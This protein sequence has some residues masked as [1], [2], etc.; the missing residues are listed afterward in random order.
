MNKT[1]TI[2]FWISVLALALGIYI[3]Q[4][5][6]KDARATG[7]MTDLLEY[8]DREFSRQPVL[9]RTVQP[10]F[11]W[12]VPG[13]GMQTAYRIVVEEIAKGKSVEI[14]DT[15]KVESGASTSVDI[16]LRVNPS[17][18]YSWKVK[19]WT[20]PYGSPKGEG[21]GEE[22]GSGSGVGPEKSRDREWNWSE[23]KEFQTAES[24]E[25]F[26]TSYYPLET[27]TESAILDREQ[28]SSGNILYDFLDDAFGQPILEIESRIEGDTIVVHLGEQLKDGSILRKPT[29]TVRYQRHEIV[30]KKGRHTYDIAITP[31]KRNTGPE[32][33]KMPDYIGEV[34]PFRYCEIELPKD[35]FKEE[36]AVKRVDRRSVNYPFNPSAAK[37]SCVGTPLD[38]VW[39]MCHYT[40]KATSFTGIYVDGD[41]ERIPYEAD[42]L[43]NQLCHYGSD[44]EFSMARRSLEH[45]LDH[46]TW[47]TEWILQSIMIA[48]NDF[49]HT[50]DARLLTNEY[51]LLKAHSLLAL[52]QPNG[53]VSTRVEPQSKDFLSSIN[54]K[55]PI[56]DIVDWPQR[57]PMVDGIPGGSDGFVF[58]DYNAVVNAYWCHAL[59]LMA[60]I[61]D[62]TGHDADAA[63]FKAEALRAVEAFNANFIDA[64]TGL[65]TDGIDTRHSSLHANLFPLAFGLVPEES[66]KTVTGY[67][68]SRG[69]SCGVYV[70]QFLLEALYNAGEAEAALNLMT[71]TKL[72]SWWNM[73]MKGATMTMEA[74]DDTFKPNQDWNHAWGAAPGNIIPFK[75]MGVSP[76]GPGFSSVLLKP[77][78]GSLHFA[79]MKIPTI[80]GDIVMKH[81]KKSGAGAEEDMFTLDIEL[82]ANVVGRLLFPAKSAVRVEGIDDR[83]EAVDGFADLGEIGPGKH[84]LVIKC[85]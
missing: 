20:K 54:R 50:G 58:T 43:I 62:V 33:I 84:H 13:V 66:R 46:P 44:R 32:A 7:L 12:I 24:L 38:L 26:T 8:T 52:K 6:Q 70:A 2:V 31:D 51:D 63:M 73:I 28:P 82:P 41:R 76:L 36:V 78:P 34:M 83:I 37:F 45:L 72:N 10:T 81:D 17:S 29:T 69:M 35:A 53:L 40:V 4:I 21:E 56:R 9:I 65:Y 3:Y 57:V 23:S 48:W 1:S 15:D 16:G 85:K 39:K 80:R 67:V 55:A 64:E 5:F 19:V 75:L 14:L 60:S 49:L 22:P 30:L 59:R 25:H 42:A 79:E 61:A 47:P 11:S 27:W 18:K 77:Q 68:A 71:S 74:W